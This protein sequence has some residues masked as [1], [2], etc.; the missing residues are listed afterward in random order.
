MPA[1]KT[2][3]VG[4]IFML[5]FCITDTIRAIIPNR[6][7]KSIEES[8]VRFTLLRTP[9]FLRRLQRRRTAPHGGRARPSRAGNALAQSD[10]R[11]PDC[12]LPHNKIHTGGRNADSA[13]LSDGA[14]PVARLAVD[15]HL[16][17][18]YAAF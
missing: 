1:A 8:Y 2:T 15:V 4:F 12:S 18:A 6:R 3:S 10:A 13:V 11:H 17:G 14:F 16:P 5:R 7:G 9:P